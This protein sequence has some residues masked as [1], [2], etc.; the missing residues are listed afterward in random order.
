[1]L[2]LMGGAGRS[3]PTGVF[4][5]G[6][7]V[8]ASHDFNDGTLGPYS[9]PWSGAG[10]PTVIADPTS[11]GRGNLVRTIYAPVSGNS[12]DF[13]IVFTRTLSFSETIWMRGDVYLPSAGITNYNANHNRK[14]VDWQDGGSGGI[15]TRITLHH[16]TTLR[17]SI[18][19]PYFPGSLGVPF[20]QDIDTGLTMARDVWHLLQIKFVMNTD[21]NRDAVIEI[22]LA[23]S[24]VYSTTTLSELVGIL[25]TTYNSNLRNCLIGSQLTIN[26]GDPAY[27]ENRY[28]DNVSFQ[29]A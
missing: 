13:S 29:S 11:S 27:S 8:W 7:T 17:I 5:G 23:G 22:Y 3:R 26:S 20:D 12:A 25:S 2:I 9:N 10:Q 14:L 24:R 18:V 4:S 15:T 16:N 19:T 28:W 6:A 21:G 1:M